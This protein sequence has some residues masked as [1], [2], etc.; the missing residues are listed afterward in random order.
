MPQLW[1]NYEGGG[2]GGPWPH[3]HTMRPPFDLIVH[4]SLRCHPFAPL[5]P[6]NEDL[7]PLC[8][9]PPPRIKTQLRHC[10]SVFPDGYYISLMQ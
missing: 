3:T 1:R 6:P 4:P 10:A 8:P 9:P 5:P 2:A 7:A